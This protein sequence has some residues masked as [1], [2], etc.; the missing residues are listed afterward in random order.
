MKNEVKEQTEFSKDGKKRP[1][2][3]HVDSLKIGEDVTE[4]AEGK[5]ALDKEI[6]I[7]K[8]SKTGAAIGH[9]EKVD[10][11]FEAKGNGQPDPELAKQK[12]KNETEAE[13]KMEPWEKE[14][15]DFKKD[16]SKTKDE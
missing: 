6:K 16:G 1:K 12:K 15:K 7:D 11:A 8:E 3:A 9:L 10:K 2:K 4:K 5:E 14:L 13:S